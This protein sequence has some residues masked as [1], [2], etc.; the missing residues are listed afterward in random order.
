VALGTLDPK[1]ALGVLKTAGTSENYRGLYQ[2]VGS[3]RKLPA[4]ELNNLKVTFRESADIPPIAEAMTAIDETHDHL[5]AIAAA[6]WQPAADHP[7]LDPAHE[8][9]ML[10]EHFAELLRTDEVKNKAEP[11]QQIL[12]ETA[13]ASADLESA[14]RT[15]QTGPKQLSATLAKVTNNCQACH[16]QF[17]DVPLREKPK[18]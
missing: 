4:A 16:Q 8:A 6:N 3:A 1:D 2:S 11:F 7:D 17:R 12:R 10:K 9:L 13:E 15:A 5:R 14:L 18:R